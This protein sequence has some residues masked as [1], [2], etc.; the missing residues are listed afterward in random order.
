MYTDA[1]VSFSS[2]NLRPMPDILTRLLDVDQSSDVK[3]KTSILTLQDMRL[4]TGVCKQNGA[5]HYLS[6][7]YQQAHDV[8]VSLITKKKN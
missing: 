8:N 4:T 1:V 5:F 3:M 7:T 6:T 2:M